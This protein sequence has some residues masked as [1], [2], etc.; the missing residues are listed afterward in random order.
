MK[1]ILAIGAAVFACAGTAAGTAAALTTTG[2]A[3]REPSAQ[4]ARILYDCA[5]SRSGLLQN[6]YSVRVLRIAQREIPGDVAD[7]T[8]CPEAIRTAIDESTSTI[9]ATIRRTR[10]GR[11]VAGTLALLDLRGRVV[12][13][14]RVRGGNGANFRVEPGRYRLRANDRRNC[15]VNVTARD[16]RTT[17]TRVICKQR[18]V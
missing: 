17:E 13:E 6:R 11:P 10:R 18:Q 12:D 7:Y 16:W 8:S 4:T 2:T 15:L 14:L 3:E 5:S 1:R 9:S